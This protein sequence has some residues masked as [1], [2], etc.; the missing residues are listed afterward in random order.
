[1]EKE[2]YKLGEK[3]AKEVLKKMLDFYEIE[4]DEIEDKDIRK[5][6]K[7]GHNRLIKAIRLER[8]KVEYPDG[9]IKIIQ[10][11]RLNNQEIV[12]R[13]IDGK[14][15]VAMASKE[16]KDYYGKS[17]ALM[18]ALSDWGEQAIVSLK[19]VD[20]SLVEVLGMIFLSV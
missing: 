18:G 3:A 13:E 11:T 6:V 17:Y 16:E 1:M 12:Y 14:A 19:G 20:S 2:K 10:Y 4:I 8:L 7:S 5:A 9:T 15:K